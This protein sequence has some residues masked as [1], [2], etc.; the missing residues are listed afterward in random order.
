MVPKMVPIH[1]PSITGVCCMIWKA[2]A[3]SQRG[4]V[5]NELTI[6]ANRTARIT[7]ATQRHGC[8]TGRA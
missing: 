3:Q 7:I 4:L 8:R 5:T 1:R 2:Y 6:I